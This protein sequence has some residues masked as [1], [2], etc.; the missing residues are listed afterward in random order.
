MPKNTLYAA[1]DGI[2]LKWLANNISRDKKHIQ[3]R[4]EKHWSTVWNFF[5]L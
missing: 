3:G 4:N 5:K 2:S 1:L